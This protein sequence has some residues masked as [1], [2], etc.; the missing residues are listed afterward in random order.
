MC[1]C[2]QYSTNIASF[3]SLPLPIGLSLPV[4]MYHAFAILG[5][6][7]IDCYRRFISTTRRFTATSGISR[8]FGPM[9]LDVEAA[10]VARRI[11]QVLSM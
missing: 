6:V 7:C 8:A 4:V 11:V 2:L 5:V 10:R 1:M 9:P 3:G